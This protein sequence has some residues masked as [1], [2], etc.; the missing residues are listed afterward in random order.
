MHKKGCH[1]D[2]KYRKRTGLLARVFTAVLEC[3][4]A[5]SVETYCK[6]SQVA[7]RNG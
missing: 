3:G 6:K 5:A 7:F 1:A 2:A 4:T